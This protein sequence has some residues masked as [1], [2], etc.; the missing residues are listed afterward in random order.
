LIEAL[1]ILISLTLAVTGIFL[2]RD[3]SSFLKGAYAKRGKVVSIQSTFFNQFNTNISSPKFVSQGFYPIIEYMH[4]NEAVRFTAIDHLAS[5]KLHVGDKVQLRIIK[6]RRKE[7]RAC[8]SLVALISL[9][10]ILGITLFTA[11][12]SG[13]TTLSIPQIFFGSF[14]IAISLAILA[15][16]FSDQDQHFAHDLKE[17]KLGYTQLFLA[18]PTAYKKWQSSFRDPVQRFKIQGSRLCGATFIGS[19]MAILSSTISPY[20][21]SSL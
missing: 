11:A 21:I 9:I 19:A 18:E 16:Y 10:T 2:F 15:L 12:V 1:T 7:N 13:N 17:T 8:K 3:Y 4:E 6:T 14:I 20:L 5:A